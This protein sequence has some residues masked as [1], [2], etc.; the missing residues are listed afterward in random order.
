MGIFGAKSPA[1]WRIGERRT[2]F[3]L[4]EASRLRQPCPLGRKH[5]HPEI[6]LVAAQGIPA[7]EVDL[8]PQGECLCV[9]CSMIANSYE[10]PFQRQ[11]RSELGIGDINELL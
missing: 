1:G 10:Q 2:G 6:C 4:F 8:T 11:D 3:L 9:F 7:E 5:L